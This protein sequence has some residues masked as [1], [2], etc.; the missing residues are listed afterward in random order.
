MKV[1]RLPTRVRLT[2]PAQNDT[3]RDTQRAAL[4]AMPFGKCL[5]DVPCERLP[6]SRARAYPTRP[7]MRGLAKH[8]G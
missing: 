3:L 4:R 5:L 2:T 7:R 1:L 8:D 6:E